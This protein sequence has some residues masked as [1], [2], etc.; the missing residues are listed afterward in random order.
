M[1]HNNDSDKIFIVINEVVYKIIH[2]SKSYDTAYPFSVVRYPGVNSR[3]GPANRT[4]IR[5]DS[6]QF[7]VNHKGPPRVAVTSVHVQI[8]V[9]STK[10]TFDEAIV[11]VTK[12]LVTPIRVEN[13]QNDAHQYARRSP[14]FV[15]GT[16]PARREAHRSIF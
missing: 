1:T 9:T 2:T 12:L 11:L 3:C 7:I 13:W 4:T 16:S 14:V 15:S 10:S 6:G 8:Q 5:R